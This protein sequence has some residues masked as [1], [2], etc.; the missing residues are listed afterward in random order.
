MKNE[1][2]QL[3]L[4]LEMFTVEQ[5]KMV[6][7]YIERSKRDTQNQ[8]ARAERDIK[9]L[10]ENGFHLGYHFENTLKTETVTRNVNL[11]W[12]DNRF[13]TEITADTWSGGVYLLY[14]VI[15]S[16][17]E[18]NE[19]VIKKYSASFGITSDNKIESYLIVGSSRAVKPRTIL[20]KID[21]KNL[22]A[23]E[24]LS[25]L[26][27]KDLNFNVAI[28]QL[29]HEFPTATSIEKRDEWIR[30]GPRYGGYTKELIEVRFEDGSYVTFE[31]LYSGEKRIY[32]VY[33]IEEEKMTNEQKVERLVKRVTK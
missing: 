5:E 23:K 11:G 10:L 29:K 27:V 30:S 16:N 21:D 1:G 31:V 6:Q 4:E 3:E 24:K 33:D 25:S 15:A 22:A 2:Q 19:L 13:E 8:I 17:P 20:D 9:F 14:D 12:G 18:N 28:S 7:E 26:I 32:K